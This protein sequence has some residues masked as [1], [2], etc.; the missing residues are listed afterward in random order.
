MS[1][2][3]IA[4][5]FL[6][7]IYACA[8]VPLTGRKQ[9]TAIPSAEIN[10]LGVDSYN[11]VVNETGLSDNQQYIEQVKRVGVRITGAVEEYLSE[12]GLLEKIGG[13]AWEYKV[14]ESDQ[15]NAFCLPGGKIAFFE[16]IM[17]VCQDDN[18]VAVVM[19]HEIAHAIAGHGNER[20]SQALVV[21][22]GG[23]ALSE[24]L[25]S[26]PQMTHDLALAAFGIGSQ[27]GVMLPY[28]RLHESEADELGLYFMS[29]AGFDPQEAPAFWQRMLDQGG[30][31]PPEFLSTHPD[32]EN[33]IDELNKNMDKAMEYYRKNE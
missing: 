20:M 11:Q 2:K 33:R 7:V 25:N 24:A 28:S 15:M 16:G 19:S 18:G 13:F 8:K 17:P 9:F 21:N 1:K 14:L 29:M 31:R 23:A 26:Q 4:I 12:N 30:D 3:I 6:L 5:A 22:L 27:I 10:A 32:P